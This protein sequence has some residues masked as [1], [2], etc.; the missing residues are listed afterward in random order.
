MKNLKKVLAAGLAALL[1]VTMCLT[2]FAEETTPTGSIEIESPKTDANADT[3]IYDAYRILDMTSTGETDNDGKYTGVAYTINSNWKSFFDG[4]GAAYIVASQ[5]QGGELNPIVV[6]VTEG[7]TTKKVTKFINITES[8]VAEFAKKAFEF[9]QAN[10]I[11][12]AVSK[13]VT[14]GATEVKFEGL[15]LGY[16]MIYPRGASVRVGDYTSIVSLTNTEPNGKI[17]QKAEYPT[18][19][20]TASDASVELGQTIT[21]TLSSKVPDT[22]GFETYEFTFKD[23]TSEGLDFDGVDSIQVKIGSAELTKD[24]DF[25]VDTTEPD[26]ALTIDLLKEENQKKTAKYTYGDE[27]V[28]TYTATVNEKAAGNVENNHATLTYN[29]DPKDSSKKTTT[30]PVEKEVY[31][32]KIV[33][34]KVDGDDK[35][36]KLAGAKFVL[37]CKEPAQAAD[38]DE[39][40][41]AEAGK[42]YATVS[43]ADK[44]K[45]SWVD[46]QDDA[47][48]VTTDDKGEASFLGLENGTYEL[49]EIEAPKGYNMKTEPT[50]VVVDGTEATVENKSSLTVTMEVENLT[51]ALLPATGGTGTALFHIIG[52]ILVFGAGIILVAKKRMSAR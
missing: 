47:A 27:I 12:P 39:I 5:P 20:K 33:I 34:N 44:V 48:V 31:S 23:K 24:V 43:D 16:Y 18:F 7:T 1:T 46:S 14:K 41:T 40:I 26:F 49:I 2:G 4:D 30:P 21:Y 13:E 8:N 50:E 19:K 22:T 45:V 42:Y 36:T 35:E 17:V 9:A 28:I 25:T 51:G 38:E 52:A 29:N 6:E 10:D 3:T 37:R 15:E 32:A 11:S